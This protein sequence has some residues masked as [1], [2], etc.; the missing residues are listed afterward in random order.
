MSELLLIITRWLLRLVYRVEVQGECRIGERTLIVANHQSFLDGV[1]LATMLPVRPMF[2]VHSTVLRNWFFRL[3]L[4][5][6]RHEGIDTTKPIAL[7]RMVA[8]VE[9]GEAVVIFPEGRITVTGSLM[10][11]YDGPAFVAVKTGCAVVSVNIDGAVYSPWSRMGGRDFPR[12][13]FPKIRMTVSPGVT[14]PMPEA[15]RA[16]DRRRLAAE[17]LRRILQES[18]YR[19]RRRRTLWEAVVDA[20]ELN[21]RG[22]KVLE[23]VNTHFAPVDYAMVLKASLALGRL[24][25]GMTKQR[26]MVGVMMPNASATVYRMFGLSAFGRVPAM[27]NFTSGARGVQAAC[28]A[29]NV[30]LVVT[31]RAFIEKAKLGDLVASLTGVEI[32]YLEDLRARLRLSDKLWILWATHNP[33]SAALA[34][35]PN[36]PALVL[37]TSGSEGAPKGV[38]L[39]HDSVLANVEQVNAVYSFSSAD[40]FLSALPLFHAFGIT[41]GVMVPLLK[42]CRVVL[43]PSPLHY[44]TVPEFVYDHDCTVLFTTNTFLAKYAQVAHPYDFYNVRHL[45]VGAEKLTDDVRRLCLDKF[46][47]RVLE[48]YG[49]TECSP[50]IALNTPLASRPGSVGEILPGMEY[51]LVPVEGIDA[52]GLL[53]VRGDNVMLGY[54]HSEKPGALQPVDSWYNTG[55]VVNM[56][57]EF[58]SIQARLKRF[59]KVAGEMVP[60]DLVERI[61]IEADPKAAHA[62][63]SYKDTNRGEALVIF[64]EAKDLD[65]EKL[66]AAARRLGAPEIAIPRR[67]V[68]MDKLPILGNGKRDYAKLAQVA[69]ESLVT[70]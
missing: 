5:A 8:L 15:P 3:V 55:D 70:R 24:T 37:F 14:I 21:G 17:R 54:L 64:T 56:S 41:G 60:L 57:G 48:G 61:A 45:I 31:S 11:V 58:I 16:R 67:I 68:P 52:G 44:R 40:S 27:L 28:R 63:S 7:K 20:A 36:E 23:D 33:R 18:A 29:A 65:R 10:K 19:A 1:L 47:L 42:G 34:V 66:K 22:R 25:S 46:G 26:E 6:V 9:A 51:K 69:S 49:A 43:Y 4:K 62:A 13:W 2:L 39:S 38:V 12:K 35:Q 50:V 53:H 30:R 59:A 32:L